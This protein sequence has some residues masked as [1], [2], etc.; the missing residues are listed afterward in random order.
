MILALAA[1]LVLGGAPLNTIWVAAPPEVAPCTVDV[2]GAA[3]RARLGQ[4]AVLQGE[5]DLAAGEMQVAIRS[6]G[7]GLELHVQAAEERELMREL[8]GPGTDCVAASETAALMIERYLEEVG[9]GI[10]VEGGP[11][12]VPPAR[13]ARWGVAFELT[14]S[15]EVA[16]LPQLAPGESTTIPS[17][18]I[19][20]ALAIG[21]RHGPWQLALR[22]TLEQ[23]GST[24]VEGAVAGGTLNVQA[25]A[26]A[27][28]GN[29]LLAAGPGS[30]RFELA[31]GVQIFSSNTT[32]SNGPRFGKT[33]STSNILPFLGIGV[34][35]QIPVWKTL[36]A[37][38][39]A[40]MRVHFGST[41][42]QVEG[43]A[44]DTAY[45]RQLD[46]EASLGVCYV[47][48]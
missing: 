38:A 30:V 17:V 1:G 15:A 41:Q 11:S 39:V 33:G 27:L 37:L 18:P 32:T 23:G 20:G 2:L 12:F 43:V 22:G 3:F 19:G 42:L 44:D 47:F 8:P 10:A 29:Y 9:T 36:S 16:V 25:E 7:Q 14:F 26:I 6:A 31:P 40:S 28:A 21:V 35:Y 45:T 4:I 13:P 34:G 5:H 24:A 48:Y 46:G